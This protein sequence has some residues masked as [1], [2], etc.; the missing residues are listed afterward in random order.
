MKQRILHFLLALAFAVSMVPLSFSVDEEIDRVTNVM[1]S[2]WERE[3]EILLEY[4]EGVYDINDPYFVLDP[5]GMSPLSGLILFHSEE[6]A[7]VSVTVGEIHHDFENWDTFH[8]IPVVGL[9]AN[10]ENLV[11][12]EMG[13][14]DGRAEQ[15]QILV[16]TEGALSSIPQFSW[17]LLQG[18]VITR[19]SNGNLLVL[20]ESGCGFYEMDLLGKIFGDYNAVAEMMPVVIELPSG[21]FLCP[22]ADSSRLIELNRETGALVKEIDLEPLLEVDHSYGFGGDWLQVMEMEFLEQEQELILYLH[23]QSKL[24]LSYPSGAFLKRDFG[25]AEPMVFETLYPSFWEYE[26]FTTKGKTMAKNLQ[27]LVQ[28]QVEFQLLDEIVYDEV[29]EGSFDLYY[30]E[31]YGTIEL[32][33]IDIGRPWEEVMFLFLGEET[34]GVAMEKDLSLD[35][36]QLCNA[37][38]VGVYD[39]AL[40][41]SQGEQGFYLDLG[42]E[43]LVEEPR[44]TLAQGDIMALQGEISADLALALKEGD[45]SM[46]KPMIVL[47]PYGNAPLSALVAF[48]TEES[49]TVE[50]TLHGKEDGDLVQKFSSIT[51]QHMLPVYGLY[52]Y[53]TNVVTLRFTNEQGESMTTVVTINTDY[54]PET[55]DSGVVTLLDPKE[56]AEGMTFVSGNGLTAYDN[57]GNI[58]WYC[59]LV[60]DSPILRLENGNLLIHSD[61]SYRQG[62]S[63]SSLYE[64]DLLGRVYHEYVL[65]GT[66]HQIQELKNGDFFI[67][68]EISTMGNGALVEGERFLDYLVILDRETGQINFEWD[69][70]EL[71]PETMAKSAYV[72]EF[73]LTW[74]EE[75]EAMGRADWFHNNAIYYEE[76]ADVITVSGKHQD[77][78]FQFDVETGEVLWVLGGEENEGLKFYGQSYFTYD[79]R[80]R[81]L[82]LDNGT[83]REGEYSELDFEARILRYDEED[84]EVLFTYL[85][86]SGMGDIHVLGDEHYLF[87]FTEVGE[88]HLVEW[89][90]G[91]VIFLLAVDGHSDYSQRMG[92]YSKVAT[93]HHLSYESSRLGLGV[94]TEYST[95]PV[96]VA[97]KSLD[98][99]IDLAVDQGD[100]L[101]FKL[102]C[103]DSHG[104]VVYLVLDNGTETRRYDYTEGEVLAINKA[105]IPAGDYDI[106][107]YCEEADVYQL[108]G[109]Y[110][111]IPEDEQA[112]QPLAPLDA[113][114][115]TEK[116]TTAT[117]VGFSLVVF[118]LLLMLWQTVVLYREQREERK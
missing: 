101:E 8:Q 48:Q 68:A 97:E 27:E 80:G 110:V 83:H 25:V 76:E 2:Q 36:S 39:L 41:F 70:Q 100:R 10:Q 14:E 15:S 45:F 49:G 84:S 6:K 17:S 24:V 92:L 95:D 102:T 85:P 50:M 71:Y 60:E 7:Q 5:Y 34:Y 112:F 16:E 58:R 78:I 62:E 98:L 99:T 59:N 29:V 23:D 57:H 104:G 113:V 109:F 116:Y 111:S 87:H 53:A 61:K 74:G 28:T 67:S 103:H 118:S 90:E 38:P 19:I 12:L 9:L 42:E 52:P 89:K 64:I 107:F 56:M 105:G 54:L 30:D 35:Y 40:L 93:Y 82:V 72:E 69:L 106:G 73:A 20:K 79:E 65:N 96:P 46:E 75:A 4:E 44:K 86:A 81:L 115:T 11:T 1:D 43:M 77:V 3:R 32:S 91:E 47:N 18:D 26:L 51:T 21:N 22:L 114:E 63:V 13:Y 31:N 33:D 117:V 66:H 88:N 94:M 108:T 55:M 37:V